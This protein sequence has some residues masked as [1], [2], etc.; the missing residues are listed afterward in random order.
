[1]EQKVLSEADALRTE[2]L[3]YEEAQRA[4][5]EAKRREELH[6]LR[7]EAAAYM[8]QVCSVV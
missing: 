6:L 2:R 7:L 5:A 8:I 3:A 4:A 1:L